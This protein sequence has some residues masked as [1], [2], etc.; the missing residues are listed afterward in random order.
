MPGT[1]KS[2]S[3][4][5]LLSKEELLQLLRPTV[6]EEAIVEVKG[7]IAVLK[8]ASGAQALLPIR[9]VCKIAERFNLKLRGYRCRK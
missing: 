2:Q 5:G 8:T 1:Q 7:D 6:E 9:E 3:S 4:G